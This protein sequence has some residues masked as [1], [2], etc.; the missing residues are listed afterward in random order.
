MVCLGLILAHSVQK[1]HTCAV[2]MEKPLEYCAFASVQL[3]HKIGPKNTNPAKLLRNTFFHSFL[4]QQKKQREYEKNS[5]N[6]NYPY[7]GRHHASR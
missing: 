6:S 2:P 5:N 4:C 3:L 7:V 1:L